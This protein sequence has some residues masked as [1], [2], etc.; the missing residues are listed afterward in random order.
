MMLNDTFCQKASE[1][2]REIGNP[3]GFEMKVTQN[4]FDFSRMRFL[5]FRLDFFEF[6]Q[7]DQY[8]APL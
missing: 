7:G 1:V 5:E 4:S 6:S 3:V 8:V 2:I